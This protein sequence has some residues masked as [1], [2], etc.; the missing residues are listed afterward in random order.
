[1]LG[2]EKKKKE[3]YKNKG[4]YLKNEKETKYKT[5]RE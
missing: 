3:K 1:M 2:N 4:K 5:I